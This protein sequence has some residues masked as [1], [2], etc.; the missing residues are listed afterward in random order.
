MTVVL[1]SE[2]TITVVV[3]SGAGGL[4]LLIQPDS[5]GTTAINKHAR[6]FIAASLSKAAKSELILNPKLNAAVDCKVPANL[7]R[8]DGQPNQ[9]PTVN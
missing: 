5:T 9:Q 8:S 3:F 4:L 2:G 1:E 7:K 6:T